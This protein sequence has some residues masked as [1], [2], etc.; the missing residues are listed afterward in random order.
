MGATA[1]P[2]PRTNPSA[3][4]ERLLARHW[5]PGVREAGGALLWAHWL[6]WNDAMNHMGVGLSVIF[7]SGGKF[8]VRWRTF[9]W[10]QCCALSVRRTLKEPPL[11]VRD[12][13]RSYMQI[14]QQTPASVSLLFLSEL[15]FASTCGWLN[16]WSEMDVIPMCSIF[17]EL[18]IVHD[19]G[20]FSALP[21][22]EEYWQQVRSHFP[23]TTTTATYLNQ[24]LDSNV[25]WLVRYYWAG[26]RGMCVI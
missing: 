23:P 10:V 20:Y 19:T 8:T 7:E 11:E 14:Q 3:Q 1:A 17:Q 6:A 25:P 12:S 21:S 16:P 5:P 18:Q 9:Q 22:L 15:E 2:Q 4:D 26:A 13:T 24:Q